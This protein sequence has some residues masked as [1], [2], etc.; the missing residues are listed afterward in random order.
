MGTKKTVA[1]RKREGLPPRIAPTASVD[2]AAEIGRDSVIGAFCLVAAG[3]RVG[4]GTRVQSHTSVWAGVT[5]DEDV[6]VG[7][8]AVFTNVKNPRADFPRAPNWDET[9]VGRGASIGANA[10][11]VAPVRVGERALVGAGSVVTRDVP[12]HAIVVGAPA[13][14]VGWACTCGETLRRDPVLP[15]HAECTR[16]ERRFDSAGGVLGEID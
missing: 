2:S 5:L 14:I 7:P 1:R 12:P 8:S 3:A 15:T 13:R 16:C 10:T 9:W 6:F 11:L 4:A